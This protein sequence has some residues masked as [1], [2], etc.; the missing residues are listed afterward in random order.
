VGLE[1]FTNY[2]PIH[3]NNIINSKGFRFIYRSTINRLNQAIEYIEQA[4]QPLLYVGGGVISA[5]ANNEL[6][7][8]AEYYKIPVTTTLRA[9]AHLTKIMT[10]H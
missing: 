9:K 5:D 4:S 8:L 2:Q 7:K 6:T 3:Q 1:E 10:Y